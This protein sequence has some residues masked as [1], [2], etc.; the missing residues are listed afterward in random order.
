MVVIKVCC[1]YRGGDDGGYKRKCI[2]L[3]TACLGIYLV[4]GS[5]ANGAVLGV[6]ARE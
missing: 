5:V 2:Q 1:M 3:L 6:L 4:S